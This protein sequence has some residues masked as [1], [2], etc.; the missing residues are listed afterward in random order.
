MVATAAAST[1]SAPSL[2]PIADTGGHRGR[3]AAAGW[4]TV[5][6]VALA[7]G[8]W[9]VA[10]SGAALRAAPLY[11]RWRWHPGWG[12]APVA[13]LA[14]VVV[15]CGPG[16]AACVRWRL[17]PALTA[18]AAAVWTLALAAA[19]GWSRVT[20]P[21]T[22]R[23]EYEPFAAG[24]DDVGGLLRHFAERLGDYPIHVQGHPPGPVVLAWLLDGV[25]LAGAGWLATVAIAG[26]ATAVA[27]ALVAARA[28]AGEVLA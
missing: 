9:A 4:V 20:A 21:I 6:V 1:D 19:D 17:L 24:I 15:S 25:G 7:W 2:P 22:S 11:G 16:M 12:L 26:W 14:G 23:H 5:V 13:V 3:F 18:L 28:V 27:A 8:T 10:D